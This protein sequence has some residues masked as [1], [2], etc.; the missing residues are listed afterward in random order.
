M[1]AKSIGEGEGLSHSLQSAMK[2]SQD[3]L[4]AGTQ[5]EHRQHCLALH[6]SLSRLSLHKPGQ[7]Q[8]A[9]HSTSIRNCFTVWPTGQSDKGIFLFQLRLGSLFQVTLACMKLIKKEK[10]TP[11]LMF[12]PS[13]LLGPSATT[14]IL[15]EWISSIASQWFKLETTHWVRR[16]KWE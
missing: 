16:K 11:S 3:E 4:R 6:D 5:T 13:K 7:P 8:W 10:K 2:G 9:G 12:H 15:T 14:L 1:L